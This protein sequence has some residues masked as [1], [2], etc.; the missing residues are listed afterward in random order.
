MGVWGMGLAQSDEFCEVY[1]RFMEAYDEGVA[2]PEIEKAILDSCHAEFDDADGVMHNVYFA[3]AKAEWMCCAPSERILRRVQEII[4]SGADLEFYRELGASP[5]DVSLRA[6]KLEQFWQTLQTPRKSARKRRPCG[7]SPFPSLRR[8]IASPTN[9]AKEGA[10]SSYSTASSSTSGARSRSFAA[11]C[12]GRL[13][14][15][16]FRPSTI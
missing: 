13:Q 15:P 9:T 7:K 10:C 2:V 8:A 11:C 3:L 6:K 1:E 4:E 5:S 12:A 16:N 14:S